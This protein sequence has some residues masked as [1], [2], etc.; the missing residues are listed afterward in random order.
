MQLVIRHSLAALGAFLA[1]HGITIM[2]TNSTSAILVGVVMWLVS[3]AWSWQTK[4]RLDDTN[5]ERILKLVGALVSQGL[6][7]L[8][9]VMEQ[10]GFTGNPDD[11]A[12]VTLFAAN[13]GA[14]KLGWH[15]KA[16]G[17]P[18][19]Q[20]VRLLIAAWCVVS[21]ASCELMKQPGPRGAALSAAEA[22]LVIAEMQLNASMQDWLN[23]D[24]GSLG[25][26]IAKGLAVAAA[27]AAFDAAHKAV[28]RERAKLI[29]APGKQP[30][31]VQPKEP[32]NVQPL[33]LQP[34]HAPGRSGPRGLHGLR[35][36]AVEVPDY[37]ARVAA[38]LS[39][40]FPA[41]P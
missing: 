30:V 16:L 36:A 9:G 15:Q 20:A 34:R 10:Q 6:A 39:T 32:V 13:L 28:A 1:S 4:T 3:L 41:S 40:A 24:K 37:G 38:Q 25:E 31:N 23:A 12:A 11:A 21:L 19:A 7:A 29:N 8:A 26:Q 33:A 22:A 5:S 27:K 18:P 2:D 14:A 17:V 35:L